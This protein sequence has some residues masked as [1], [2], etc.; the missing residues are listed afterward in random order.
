VYVDDLVI[1]GFYNDDILEFKQEMQNVFKMSDLALLSY[2]L[3]IE[4]SQGPARITLSQAAYT[5]KLLERCGM[6]D[7]NSTAAPME[8]K[9]KL[10]KESSTPAVN[11]IEYR[12]IIGGLRYLIHTRSDLTY[13]VG[14]LSRFMEAP[15]EDHLSALKRVLRYVAG[16][17]GLGL[18]YTRGEAL[19]LTGYNDADLAGD[20]DQCKST[21]GIIFFL[22]DNPITWQSSKKKVVAL[23]FCEV[24]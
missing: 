18:H 13:S 22:G 6:Q 20:V 11:A 8:P 17:C 23:S 16:T 2:Y 21:S 19:K 9:L 4:V 12:K 3:N 24:E 15:H 10:S 7:Y 5:N 1:T 14:F